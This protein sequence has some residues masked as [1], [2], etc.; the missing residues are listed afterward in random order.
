MPQR[1]SSK[2]PRA[3]TKRQF[4]KVSTLSAT[5]LPSA[6]L[7]EPQPSSPLRIGLISDVHYAD[8][9][10][11][12][13]RHY[14][15]SISKMREAV[16]AFNLA[17]VDRVICL[18]D[19]IDTGATIKKELG[20]LKTIRKEIDRLEAPI[21]YVLGNHC[22]WSLT[23]DEFL[24]GVG[25]SSAY[26]S[27]SIHGVRLILLDACHRADGVA[28]GRQNFDWKDAEI[29]EAQQAWLR[30]TLEESKEPALVFVHHRLDLE[31]H[32]AVK[33]AAS[34]R[35]ILQESQKVA[36][37][38]QG[39]NHL[40]EHKTIEGI[41][42]LTMQAMIEG[43]WPQQNAFSILSFD[44]AKGELIIEGHHSQSSYRI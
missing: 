44:S 19:L 42:Y 29:P 32:Y 23:K 24:T 40:N 41:H 13:N 21:H 15:D 28:Y 35:Q 4:L 6:I 14:R 17:K 36:A 7:S 16:T 3:F 25:Q 43:I 34:V 12:G 20:H 8:L 5:A 38:F 27:Q 2:I 1:F 9:P 33:S 26:L 10:T 22:V 18:G 31:N 39:H 37:V 30:T 11:A